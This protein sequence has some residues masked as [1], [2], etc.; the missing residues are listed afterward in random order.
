MGKLIDRLTRA[1]TVGYYNAIAKEIDFDPLTLS[2]YVKKLAKIG[3]RFTI[4]LN[5]LRIGL[6][7]YVT[8][9]PGKVIDYTDLSIS[10]NWIR[11]HSITYS[12]KG[13]F[14]TFNIPFRLKEELAHIISSEIKKIGVDKFHSFFLV[15]TRKQPS[16]I[17]YSLEFHPL[18]TGYR[19]KVLEEYFREAEFVS[20]IEKDL[21]DASSLSKLVKEPRD[22]LDLIILKE[23]E[24]DAFSGLLAVHETYGYERWRIKRH[25]IKHIVEEG[26]ISGIFAK[27]GVFV[28]AFGSPIIL[29]LYVRGKDELRRWYFFFNQLE[30]VAYIGYD[31]FS[32]RKHVVSVVLYRGLRGL[33]SLKHFLV[34]KLRE[35]LLEDYIAIDYLVHAIKR[36]TIPYMGYYQDAKRWDVD[37]DK[38]HMLFERRVLRRTRRG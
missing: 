8:Y 14:I 29:I 9:I 6:I 35:G 1:R 37:I 18:F 33:E 22:L 21:L 5:L 7:E 23:L 15:T 27:G 30:N 12:P 20:G 17:K 19:Y 10:C 26:V 24:K 28:R 4:D 2:E 31:P 25:L 3:I 32:S 34:V 11:S 16:F 13:T 38:T 36:F